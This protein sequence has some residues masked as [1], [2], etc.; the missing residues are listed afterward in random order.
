MRCIF[1][2]AAMRLLDQSTIMVESPLTPEAMASA[3]LTLGKAAGKLSCSL[4][5]LDHNTRLADNPLKSL[6]GA[7]KSFKD[8]CDQ[9][10]TALDELILNNKIPSALP[11]CADNILWHCLAMQVE[12]ASRSL[13]VLET[14]FTDTGKDHSDSSTEAQRQ[15]NLDSKGHLVQCSTEIS[16]HTENLRITLLTINV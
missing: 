10:H 9:V 11:H 1:F 8:M 2:L 3:V 12:Q 14:Y 4:S 7:I 16:G 13:Q 5:K 6:C 15:L